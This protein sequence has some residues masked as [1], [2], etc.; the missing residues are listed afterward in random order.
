MKIK[1]LCYIANEFLFGHRARG[2]EDLQHLIAFHIASVGELQM[3]AFLPKLTL[4]TIGTCVSLAR[5]F[6]DDSEGVRRN[7]DAKNGRETCAL[8]ILQLFILL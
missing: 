2:T 7:K 1:H 4:R 5:C 3:Q 8:Y 6:G